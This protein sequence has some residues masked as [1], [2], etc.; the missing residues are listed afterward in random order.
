[1]KY[2]RDL[3]LEWIEKYFEVEEYDK[4]VLESCEE[5]IISKG[6]FIFFAKSNNNILGTFALIKKSQNCLELNK[7]A[8]KKIYRGK[9][10]G[11]IMIQYAIN[12]AKKNDW[13]KI[14]LYSNTILKNSIYLYRK[15]GFNECM[16][17]K[18]KPYL[19]SN[20]KMVLFIK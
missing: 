2:F 4:K 6:G 14:I 5:N 10:I 8:V 7:M 19:R 12:F 17:E 16:I 9:G 11:N 15:Y 1:M 13:K 18:N 20:I 3:N